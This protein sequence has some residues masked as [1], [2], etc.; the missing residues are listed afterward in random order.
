M[1]VDWALAVA[2]RAAAAAL[3]TLGGLA[4]IAGQH[5]GGLAGSIAITTGTAV[6]TWAGT[7]QHQEDRT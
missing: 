4:V 5:R 2:T 3:I 1:T 6:W 7:I